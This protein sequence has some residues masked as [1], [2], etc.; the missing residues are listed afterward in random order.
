[1]KMSSA[2]TATALS[3]SSQRMQ[4]L[5]ARSTAGTRRASWALRRCRALRGWSPRWTPAARCIS[6]RPPPGRSR[7]ALPSLA[8]A[9][10]RLATVRCLSACISWDC[11]LV[12]ARPPQA[13][14]APA[15]CAGMPLAGVRASYRRRPPCLALEHC[16]NVQRV[17]GMGVHTER[18]W[19]GHPHPC[20][21]PWE[22]KLLRSRKTSR[23]KACHARSGA[24]FAVPLESAV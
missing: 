8:P 14:R 12:C 3:R 10:S 11:A 23:G 5:Q 1:M 19:V 17:V 13:P 9:P 22:A 4:A 6:G 21:V 2:P 24:L 15:I 16:P 7:A 20:R 18:G